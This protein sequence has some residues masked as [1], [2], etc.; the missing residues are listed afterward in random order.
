MKIESHLENLQESITEIELIIKQGN[1]IEKQRSLGFHTSA[2][3]ADMLEIILHQQNLIDPGFVIKHEWFNSKNKVQEKFHFSFP[4][5]EEILNLIC[6]IEN[7]RNIFCYGKR[8]EEIILESV[9]KDF[10]KLKELFRE[11]TQYEL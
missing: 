8:Q 10:L 4:K 7:Q 1:L 11:A 6:K 9:V 5:K 3:S 2:A